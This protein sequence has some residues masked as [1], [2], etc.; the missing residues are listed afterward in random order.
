MPFNNSTKTNIHLSPK[1]FESKNCTMTVFVGIPYNFLSWDRPN[2]LAGLNQL[3]RYQPFLLDN[4]ISNTI[5]IYKQTINKTYTNSFL[6]IKRSHIITKMHNN[7]NTEQAIAAS[8]S[9][10][11]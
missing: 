1:T 3:M 5:D 8:V 9:A 6:L 11:S 4:W 2:I 7:I 10:H